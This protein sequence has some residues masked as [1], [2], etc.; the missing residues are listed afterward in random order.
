MKKRPS[1]NTKRR[2]DS[3]DAVCVREE[4]KDEGYARLAEHPCTAL[5]RRTVPPWSKVVA[6]A[7]HPAWPRHFID[8]LH[9]PLLKLKEK[10]SN[11]PIRLLMWSDCAGKCTERDAC[12]QLAVALWRTLG[13]SVEFSLYAA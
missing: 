1:R 12:G 9:A 11:N 4:D 7:E 13:L 5:C 2:V 3:G 8:T 6:G 10:F